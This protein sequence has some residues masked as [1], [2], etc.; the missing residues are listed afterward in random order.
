M[1][2]SLHLILIFLSLSQFLSCLAHL[3]TR[4]IRSFL[5]SEGLSV[6]IG[7]IFIFRHAGSNRYTRTLC[8]WWR[9]EWKEIVH[10]ATK[11]SFFNTRAPFFSLFVWVWTVFSSCMDSL[12]HTIRPHPHPF[13]SFVYFV[14]F[15]FHFSV[16]PFCSSSICT[17][18]DFKADFKC[19]CVYV[20]RCGGI[21][22]CLWLEK[23]SSEGKKTHR[24]K[25]HVVWC[26]KT[27]ER[28]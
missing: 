25:K 1:N 22:A 6:W 23:R 5:S 12:T 15:L 3:L 18:A 26:L 9:Y 14:S 27:C 11:S 28:S 19:V 24:N 7:P 16:L 4:R 10:H 2:I 13:V 20:R 21:I 17:R 8:K